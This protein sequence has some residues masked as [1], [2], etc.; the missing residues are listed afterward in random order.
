MD[1]A[2]SAGYW[3]VV[4]ATPKGNLFQSS[5]SSRIVADAKK[6]Y[7]SPSARK[8]WQM[9]TLVHLTEEAI[10]VNELLRQ[11]KMTETPYDAAGVTRCMIRDLDMVAKLTGLK[12]DLARLSKPAS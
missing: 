1:E 12:F 6:Q 8:L 9:Q 7:V 3:K 5:A 10:V 4:E 11:R 2:K